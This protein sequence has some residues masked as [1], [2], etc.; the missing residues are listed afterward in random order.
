[1]SLQSVCEQQQSGKKDKKGERESEERK[2]GE[3]MIFFF[4]SSKIS[5][6]QFVGLGRR[7]KCRVNNES[8]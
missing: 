5:M 2:R 3:F 6:L 4:C 1:M 8:V 7:E